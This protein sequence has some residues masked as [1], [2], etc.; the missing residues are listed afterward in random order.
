MS[1]NKV[2]PSDFVWGAATSSYQIEGAAEN[3][4]RGSCIWDEFCQ[5]PGRIRGGDTGRVACEHV[6]RFREDVQFMKQIG[7]KAYRFSVCWP[8]VIPNGVGKV[9]DAGLAFYDSLVDELLANDIEPWLTL[10]H[11]DFPT[12]LYRRGGWLNPNV[13]DWFAEYTRIIV[14]RLSDRVKHWFT[15]NEPQVFI[16]IAHGEAEHAPGTKLPLD[17]QLRMNHNVLLAHGKSAKI[18]RNEAKTVPLIGWAPVGVCGIPATESIEDIDAAR[19][20]TIG[21][22]ENPIWSNTLYNDPVFFGSYPE[23]LEPRM[24]KILHKD[25]RHDMDTICQPIDFFGVNIYR[26]DLVRAGKD[27][28]PDIIPP[29]VGTPRSDFGWEIT[30]E[31]LRWGAQ[32]LFERYQKPIIITENGM[33]NA[34]WI[35]LSGRVQD[36]QRI[37]YIARH[38][39]ALHTAMEDGIPVHGYF[40]WSLLDNFEWA[41]GYHQRFGLIHVDF[42]TQQRTLKSSAHYY[43]DVIRSQ[44]KVIWER[45]TSIN[46]PKEAGE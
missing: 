18:I 3:N 17:D 6:D 13:S 2:F 33:S 11:W 30:P 20:R 15:L 31:V 45:A 36:P 14:N 5:E 27:G 28:K 42:V 19:Q 41:E 21:T 22:G 23:Q 8:R 39:R 26:G 35:D 4:Q 44:G 16:G 9:N 25:W 32:F 29:C 34:D 10:Y 7:L 43:G 24:D 12:S 37:D 1:K 46:S 38:L 40:H